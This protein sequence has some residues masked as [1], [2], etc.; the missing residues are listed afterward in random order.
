MKHIL[1]IVAVKAL[2]GEPA[3]SIIIISLPQPFME[4]ILLI[5]VVEAKP[6]EP[7]HSM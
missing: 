2:H 1:L 4:H 7:A 5:V 3:H 6:G